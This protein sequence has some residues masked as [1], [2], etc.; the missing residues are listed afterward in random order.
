M[1][2]TFQSI[3]LHLCDLLTG[4]GL[5]V[6]IEFSRFPPSDPLFL[7]IVNVV[8][9]IEFLGLFIRL[10]GLNNKLNPPN[11]LNSNNSHPI[12][13]LRR[14]AHTTFHLIIT[15]TVFL[16]L[17]AKLCPPEGKN[18]AL[19]PVF[20]LLCLSRLKG[21]SAAIIVQGA[22]SAVTAFLFYFICTPSD[23][24]PGE[25]TKLTWEMVGSLVLC[26][27]YGGMSWTAHWNSMLS[28]WESRHFRN[29][30][31]QST[32]AQLVGVFIR[33]MAFLLI[34]TSSTSSFYSILLPAK[35]VSDTLLA[36]YGVLLMFASMRMAVS[37]F[38]E[39]QKVVEIIS[40]NSYSPRRLLRLQHI[41]YAVVMAAAWIFPMQMPGLRALI[42]FVL[43]GVD[44]VFF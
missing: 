42:I 20:V 34:G 6:F 26:L 17:V 13:P 5:V 38:E 39:L 32:L 1:N 40:G 41:L 30:S 28:N 24:R 25:N 35:S 23:L 29:Y 18:L 22:L 7:V 21:T 27:I 10:Y 15:I 19:I 43:T 2:E 9:G 8:I 12:N 36:F 31:F 33:W 16:N 11:P 3:S 4:C 14:L 44:L 37:W